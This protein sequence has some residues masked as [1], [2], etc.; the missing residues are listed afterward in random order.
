MTLDEEARVRFSKAPGEAELRKVERLLHR[1][2]PQHR[3]RWANL[4]NALLV[5]TESDAVL[6]PVLRAIQDALIALVGGGAAGNK[7]QTTLHAL[8][9][10]ARLPTDTSPRIGPDEKGNT[11]SYTFGDGMVQF[12]VHLRFDLGLSALY[13]CRH[14]R[15]YHRAPTP[16]GALL[17]LI[18]GVRDPGT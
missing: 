6:G 14:L 12:V 17:A 16:P 8:V 9:Q 2:V 3:Q 5:E 4:L 1:L 18:A 13:V 11:H 7:L 15:D 10:A